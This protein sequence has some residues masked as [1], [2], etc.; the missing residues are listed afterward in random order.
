MGDA[1]NKQLVERFVEEAFNNGNLDVVDEVYAERFESHGPFAGGTQG[2][3][4]VKG[5]VAT[6]R[7]AFPNGQTVVEGQ[8]EEGDGVAYRWT[9]R[10]TH[11]GELMGIPPTGK[12]VTISGITMI[13]AENGRIVAQWNCFDVMGML[14]QLGAAP[15]LAAAGR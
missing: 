7:N 1:S 4:D 15:D 13:R 9:F 6:Y 5:F 8:V 2:R 10:G 11:N 3:E 12:D 14:Q